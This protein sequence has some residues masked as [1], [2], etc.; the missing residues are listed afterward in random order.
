MCSF[1]TAVAVAAAAAEICQQEVSHFFLGV[2]G[3]FVL[4]IFIIFVVV[5]GGGVGSVTT[6]LRLTQPQQLQNGHTTKQFQEK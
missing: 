3:G 6:S 2:F 1:S 4:V 5:G